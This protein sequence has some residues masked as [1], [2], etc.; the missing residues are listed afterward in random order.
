MYFPN[1]Q[2]LIWDLL[3][4]LSFFENLEN[5]EKNLVRSLI[6]MRSNVKKIVLKQ[7]SNRYYFRC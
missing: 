5:L 1:P 7:A 6:L 2:H 4:I 3:T